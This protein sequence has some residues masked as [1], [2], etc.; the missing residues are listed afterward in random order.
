LG[1]VAMESISPNESFSNK[2][3]EEDNVESICRVC[4]TEGEPDR[5]LFY[6]CRCSGSIKFI[7]EVSFTLEDN[8]TKQ[9]CLVTWLKHSK[10]KTCELCKTAYSFQPSSDC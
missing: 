10:K 5:P 1:V 7:H 2:S 4:R 6:P 8:N 9:D 3:A